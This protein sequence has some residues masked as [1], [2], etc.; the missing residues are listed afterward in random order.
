LVKVNT[1]SAD[2]P[3]AERVAFAILSFSESPIRAN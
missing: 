2:V 3:D 1:N